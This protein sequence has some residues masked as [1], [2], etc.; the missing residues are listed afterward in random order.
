[1]LPLEYFNVRNGPVPQDSVH[2]IYYS[3]QFFN[4]GEVFFQLQRFVQNDMIRI[5][6]V[7]AQVTHMENIMNTF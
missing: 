7:L 2:A 6:G 5:S 3:H 4:V 1:M